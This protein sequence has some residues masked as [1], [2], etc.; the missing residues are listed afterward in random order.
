M[1]NWIENRITEII[2]D[3]DSPFMIVWLVF[4][5]ICMDFYY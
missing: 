3:E 1:K 5:D 2:K 4:F